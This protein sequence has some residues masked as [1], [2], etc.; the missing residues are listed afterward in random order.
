MK[1]VDAGVVVELL[2]GGL[3]PQ[4]LGHEELA[5]PHLVDS[6][7]THVLRGLARRGVIDAEQGGLAMEGFMRLTLTRFPA[8]GLRPRMWELRDNLSAYDATFVALAE[9][10]DAT[11]LLT[12][13]A[14]LANAPGPRCRIE[15]L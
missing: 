15:L 9:L 13:D 2:V 11:A 10:T 3:D 8:D 1:V 4:R 6:E 5:A 12:T 7:V 14:R